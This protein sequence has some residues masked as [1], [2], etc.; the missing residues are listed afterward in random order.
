MAAL[1]SLLPLS[2]IAGTRIGF[3]ASSS[4][5]QSNRRVVLQSESNRSLSLVVRNDAGLV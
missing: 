5:V 4:P 2:A 1:C 3:N